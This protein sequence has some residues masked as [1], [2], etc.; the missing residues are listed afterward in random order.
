MHLETYYI[1]ISILP[2][3]RWH[4]WVSV[5]NSIRPVKLSNEV[6]TLLSV[7][8]DVQVI[9]IWSSWCHCHPIISYFIK[10]QIGVTFLVPAYPGCPGNGCLHKDKHYDA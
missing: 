9:G 1:R 8:S 3:V 6:L 4:R 10:I 5:R 7:S 2:S